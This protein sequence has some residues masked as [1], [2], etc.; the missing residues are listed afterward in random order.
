[1][2]PTSPTDVMNQIYLFATQTAMA[3]ME[4][5]PG[6]QVVTESPEAP[7]ATGISITKPSTGLATPLAVL[8]SA[9]PAP[10]IATPPLVVPSS[11]TLKKG[12]F[13][14]CIA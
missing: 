5:T 10:L 11:Y 9:T 12:E 6:A 7:V 13:P 3:K 1:M 2:L 14:Y 8:P 4:T